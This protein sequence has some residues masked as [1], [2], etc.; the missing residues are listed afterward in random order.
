MWT[1]M[2]EI[3]RPTRDGIHGRE[4]INT[5][6]D[7]GSK[8]MRLHFDASGAPKNEASLI[9][10]A[11]PAILAAAP[12]GDPS[13]AVVR[14]RVRAAAEL[15]TLAVL[16]AQQLGALGPEQH[17]FVVPL[18]E[19]EELPSGKDALAR[20]RMAEIA[21]GPA[22]LSVVQKL[23]A[24]APRL[25]IGV[26]VAVRPDTARRVLE[27]HGKGVAILHLCADHQGREA[28]SERPRFIKEVLREVHGELVKH[29]M[30]DEVT[31][32][33]SGGIALAEHV[34]KAVICGAD[35]VGVDI[36]LLVALGC[37]VCSGKHGDDC[38][39]RIQEAGIVY[40][41]Q[42]MINLMGAWH[43]Q[44]IEVLGAMGVRE[45][46]RLRGEVGRAM[47]LED[48]ERD[49]F[50]DLARSPAARPAGEDA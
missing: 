33:A 44:L 50:K 4:Y 1:D 28:G 27:L 7:I 37:R 38:P 32:I 8:P 49:A 16:P 30:R 39:A 43:S 10:V 31:L 36:P 23:K 24:V 40:A 2:S 17:P 45:V 29:G 18:F 9:E 34:A 5:S 6:V 41:A 35:L 22:V 26:R 19:G 47:F 3:V 42:R 48:L 13:P 15:H 21:D 25:L 20:V 11:L 12:W 46:R 14:A